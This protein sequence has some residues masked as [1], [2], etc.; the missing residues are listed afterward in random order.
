MTRSFTLTKAQ[1]SALRSMLYP[2]DNLESA[3]ILIC[4]FTG[5]QKE[6][7]IVR[8]IL[9]VPD[10]L[11]VHR[12]QDFI[13]WPGQCVEEAIDRAEPCGDAIIL[14]HSHPG[15]MFEFS[16]HDNKSDRQ[17]MPSLFEAINADGFHHGSAI[18][19]PNGAIKVRLYRKDGAIKG[20]ARVLSVG[21]DLRELSANSNIPMAFGAQMTK[22]LKEQTACVVGVSGTGSL[23]AELLARMGVG[24]LI[25][26]DFDIMEPK[27]LNR[28]VNSTLQDAISNRSKVEMMA[29]AIR[30][31]SPKV[32]VIT[33]QGSIEEV[34][35]IIAA[36][37]ADIIFSCVDRM[38][39]RSFAELLAQS[40]LIP[41]IDLGV[42][43]PTRKDPAGISHIADVCGRI[44]YVWPG[45][46]NLT[47]RNVVTPEGLR[48]EYLETNA[49]ETAQR[50]LDAGYLKG[51]H[52]EA[53]SVM[54]LNMRVAGDA[55]LEW[56]TR[57][58]NFR[59]DGNE[60]F[61]RTLFS[62]AGGEI[63][64][65]GEA[66]FT[67]SEKIDLG[68]GLAQPLLGLPCMTTSTEKDAA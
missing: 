61:A 49:P 12:S 53:P 28:I 22:A 35:A 27:N 52:E 39:G 13:K 66:D 36:S 37:A 46:P 3:A 65:I 38:T 9:N 64:Y 62:L 42:T 43:I 2:G 47:D 60:G 6:R 7:L 44:D 41:L 16:K 68:R 33:I 31:Y 26:I 11:C 34:D 29:V 23:V 59:H 21:T 48:R 8:D 24:R 54:A 19:T 50:E 14:I 45:G 67:L 55:V 5:P 18:M 25:L 32:K 17:T 15:G 1:H 40:C 58:F 56:T 4:R 57:L 10:G 30:Q 51:V 20:I 63:D